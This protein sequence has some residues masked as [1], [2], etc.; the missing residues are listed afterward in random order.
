MNWSKGKFRVSIIA[1]AI[2]AAGVVYAIGHEVFPYLSLNHDEGVYLQQASM[3]L[4]GNLWLTT[5]FPKVFRPW[6]FIQDGNRLYP[7]YTPVSALM[8]AP[9]LALGVPRLSLSL[10]AA[11]NVALVG[12]IAREA[13]DRPTGVLASVFAL[14]TPFFMIISATF[15]S[16]APT[17]LLNLVFALG[18]IRMHRRG[19]KRYAVIAGAAIGV[20]FFSRPYTAVLFAVPFV[21]HALVVVARDVREREIWTPTIER[22][23]VVALFGAGGVGIALAYNYVVTGDPFLF[24]YRVFAPHDGLGFGPHSLTGP[25]TNYTIGLALWANSVLVIELLTRWT[26]GAPI[27]SVLAVIGLFP[28]ALHYREDNE[29][30]QLSDR[31]LRF[32]LVGVFISVVVGNIY[33]WG[34]NNILGGKADPTNGFIA[35]F[36][37]YYHLD[38]VLPLSVFAAVGVIWLGRTIRSSISMHASTR[39]ARVVVIALLVVSVPIVASAEY[40]RVDPVIERNMNTTEVSATIYAPFENQTFEH[41]LVFLPTPYSGWLS[42]PFQWLRNGGSLEQGDVL[43]AENLGPAKQ[44][45]LIDAFPN[46]TPYRF[47]YRGFWSERKKTELDP[48]LQQLA[49]R[50]GTNHRL[51]TTVGDVGQL[52]AV[53]LSVGDRVV[54]RYEYFRYRSETNGTVTV[55]WAVNGTHVRLVNAPG[56]R[57]M[58]TT[59]R[60]PVTGRV[61]PSLTKVYDASGAIP[62]NET[63]YASLSITFTKPNGDRITYRQGVAIDAN[64][65][66]ARILWPGPTKVCRGSIRC[67]RGGMYVPSGEY[68]DGITMNTTARTETNE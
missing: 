58:T 34:T 26:V 9:S 11:G 29:E 7:K 13:F 67:G 17:L 8:F 42:H 44:F 28:V 64:N 15:M 4:H 24:P 52:S 59:T 12:L 40:N 20:S 32:V 49:V 41:A 23:V 30:T 54:A 66:T 48:H 31:V 37:P 47:T 53:R 2:L 25:T 16:Y 39:T 1:V 35:Y 55:Q 68:P 46:R 45:A 43:Y 61:V 50:N 60:N 22:E 21:V 18:Y 6:F 38:L 36:G 14:A 51:T 19:G 63:R 33:F 27:G 56:E 62:V 3:L 5:D 65:A 10:I 57:V